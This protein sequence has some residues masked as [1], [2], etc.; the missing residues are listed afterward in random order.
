MGD[1]VVSSFQANKRDD[2][3]AIKFAALL[4]NLQN[5]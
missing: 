4:K 3:H 5:K 2:A 1:I